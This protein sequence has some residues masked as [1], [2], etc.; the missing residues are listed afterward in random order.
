MLPHSPID[1][2]HG[3]SLYPA[4]AARAG[5]EICICYMQ[6]LI[7]GGGGGGGGGGGQKGPSPLFVNSVTTSTEC[8]I[9]KGEQRLINRICC[10]I[11]SCSYCATSRVSVHTTRVGMVLVVR[12]YVSIYLEKKQASS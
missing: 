9:L 11:L 1:G 6:G 2:H 8:K 5:Y 3:R 12:P 10:Y 4:H 7:H